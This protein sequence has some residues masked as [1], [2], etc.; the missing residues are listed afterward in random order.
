M[1][2]AGTGVVWTVAGGV[3]ASR[4]IGAGQGRR[5]AAFPSCRSP[6]ATSAST[7]PPTPTRAAT[8]KAAIDKVLALPGQAGLHD[9]HRRHHPSPRSRSS[10]TTRRK[11]IGDARLDVHYAPGEHDIPIPRRDGLSRTL[12]QGR[13]GRRLVRLRSGRRAFRFA[14]Q[15][16]RPQ[17]QRSG[18]ARARAARLARR[19]SARQIGLDA[20][21]R[22]RAYPALDDRAGMG[23]GH[24]G[25]GAGAAAARALRLG[26]RA[27]RPHPSTDAE[28]RR[29]GD[30]PYRALDRL[31]A[32]RAGNRAGAGA[33]ARA[34]RRI[35]QISRRRRGR[36]RRRRA[37]PLAI[38]DSALG[39]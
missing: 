3:P 21:R 13:D 34:G 20:D 18:L 36:L 15:R 12:R 33:E 10:S 4:L 5:D 25:F 17:D 38:T 23:L 37:S 7:S 31:P 19:R 9:P 8:L 30:L 27:Q 1:V 26:D 16:R 14:G 32:A 29:R 11:S 35:A 6:T 2:W 22:L 39:S 28:G 24:R